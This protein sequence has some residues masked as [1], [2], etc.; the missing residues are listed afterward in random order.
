MAQ[1]PRPCAHCGN[2]S[3]TI[4]PNICV[5]LEV[6]T[7]FLGAF[8]TKEVK[9]R[10]WVFSLAICAQCGCTQIFTANTAQL[11]QWVPSQTM[12]VPVR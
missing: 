1:P 7:T 8:A 5:D 6:A 11:A 2:T 9:G 4:V 10:H 12:T 3:I